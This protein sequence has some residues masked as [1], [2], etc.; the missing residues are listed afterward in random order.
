MRLAEGIGR[1]L[2]ATDDARIVDACASFGAQA[3]LT[4][5]DH[6]SGTDRIAEVAAQLPE[7]DT[8]VNVQGDEP[9]VQPEHVGALVRALIESGLPMATLCEPLDD[10]SAANP[11]R[12]KVVTRADGRALYFSRSPIPHNR[13]GGPWPAGAGYRLHLGL[14]AYRREFLLAYPTL[15]PA[16]LEQAEKL[17][18]L[19]ALYHGYDI[20]VAEVTGHRP[21]IDTPEDYAAF[22]ARWRGGLT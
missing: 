19:R 5:P 4:R 11:N 15:P 1:V 22:V 2:V 13:D 18:Q 20:A 17:E 16:P 12:V 6:P 10:A 7:A 3:V 8:I 9:E 14:Y 21:G